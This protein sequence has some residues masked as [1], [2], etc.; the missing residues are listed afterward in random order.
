M[1]VGAAMWN[2]CVV[3]IDM[4]TKVRSVILKLLLVFVGVS[5]HPSTSLKKET[6]RSSPETKVVVMSHESQIY[7]LRYM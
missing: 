1:G 5:L 6:V 3:L 7:V 4:H 2:G